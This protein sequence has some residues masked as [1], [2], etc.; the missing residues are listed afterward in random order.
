M[1]IAMLTPGTGNFH[2]GSC[3]H[4]ETLARGLRRLGHEVLMVPLYLPLVL[5]EPGAAILNDSMQATVGEDVQM[6]GINLY[7]QQ[8]SWLFRR[9]PMWMKRWLDRP[10]LLYRAAKRSDMTSPVELGRMTVEMLRGEHGKTVD[11]LQR[12]IDHLRLWDHADVVMLN[13]ALL[14]SAAKPIAEALGCRVVCTLQGEDTFLD[15]LPQP[16]RDQAWGLLREQVGDVDQFVAVSR[17]HADLMTARLG[18]P[19][20][21]VAV[22]YNGIDV[23]RYTNKAKGGDSMSACEVTPGSMTIGYLARLCPTK[24]M[25][26]LVDAFMLLHERGMVADEVHLRLVGS[27][28]PTNMKFVRDQHQRL[29]DAGHGDRVVIAPN[30]T[31]DEKLSHLRAMSVLSVPAVYGESFG[32]YVL[33]ALACGVPV[34]Q[35]R[36]AAFPE[37]IE[38][39]GGGMLYDLEEVEMLDEAN[40][41]ADALA[42]M[43]NDDERRARLGRTGQD[44]VVREFTAE[45]MAMQ[46][47]EILETICQVTIT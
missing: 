27:A 8:K 39:T 1:K 35:P 10:S 37:V 32:L 22:V 4:D 19:T 18:L 33:E 42:A 20:D 16:W 36:H 14:M 45:R 29:I 34:V 46:T 30:V 12:L 31:F 5:D 9:I 43:L 21:R 40:A 25:H 44:A 38:R 26:T 3:L 6:G 47:S 13:N 41:L 23:E 15:D 11:E 2:C 28:T 24:G 17:Y 7:L